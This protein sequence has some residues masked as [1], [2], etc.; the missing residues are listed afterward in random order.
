M[1]TNDNASPAA[2]LPQPGRVAVVIGS[3]RPSRICPGIAEWVMQVAQD[4]SRLQYEVLD[5]AEVNLPFLDE[6]LQAALQHYE[7]EHTRAWSR[8]VS[9]F[10]GFIFVFPQYNWGYPAP[11]KNAL[12]YL[13]VEWRDKPASYVTYGTRGG[14]KA[15]AQFRGLLGGLHMQELDD[16]LEVIITE[17]DVDGNWQLRDLDATLR[18]Y[19][20]ETRKIDAEMVEALKD[21]EAGHPAPR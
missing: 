9:A 19:R 1:A 17:D 2:A 12:D 7:H 3:T 10:D 20:A 18:P 14:N 11:L 8:I 16:H 6:P 15:A 13:Y 4:G 5:L 21:T